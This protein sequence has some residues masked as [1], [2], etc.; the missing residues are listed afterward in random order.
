[1]YREKE[2]DFM[3]LN[4]HKFSVILI[5]VLSLVLLSTVA[6][7][8]ASL[9]LKQIGGTGSVQKSPDKDDYATNE[10]V[11]IEATPGTGYKFVE[12]QDNDGNTLT[13]NQVYTF[14]MPDTDTTYTAVYERYDY[15]VTVMQGEGSYEIED[16]YP[17]ITFTANP[18]GGF[19]FSH[20]SGDA[21]PAKQNQKSMTITIEEDTE[22]D[23]NFSQGTVSDLQVTPSYVVFNT[24]FREFDFRTAAIA[25]DEE[26]QYVEIG[27]EF[28]TD[29]PSVYV[30]DE[31]G[32]PILGTGQDGVAAGNTSGGIYYERQNRK[33]NLDISALNALEDGTTGEVRL[34]SLNGPRL[35][36]FTIRGSFPKPYMEVELNNHP[37]YG[38]LEPNQ[39]YFLNNKDNLTV[40]ITANSDLLSQNVVHPFKINEPVVLGRDLGLTSY[41]WYEVTAADDIGNLLN[42]GLDEKY[43]LGE[44]DD[45][46]NWV[47]DPAAIN[48]AL[49]QAPAGTSFRIAAVRMKAYARGAA[50]YADQKYYF[51]IDQNKPQIASVTPGIDTDE[52]EGQNLDKQ[53]SLVDSNAAE[54]AE[55][56]I[57]V[58]FNEL[59][60]GIAEEEINARAIKVDDSRPLDEIV[61]DYTDDFDQAFDQDV[62]KR[63]QIINFDEQANEA[64]IFPYGK[65]E[66]GK[67]VVRITVKDNAGNVND[68]FDKEDGGVIGFN[69]VLKVNQGSPII[70]NITL[71][72]NDG[73]ETAGIISTSGGRLQFDV[74]NSE[75]LR[76]QVRRRDKRGETWTYVSET[77]LDKKTQFINRT[78]SDIGVPLEDGTYEVIMVADDIKLQ[79]EVVTAI[80]AIDINEGSDIETEVEDA[81]KSEL[82]AEN[83][84][85]NDNRTEVRAF[86]FRVD[87]TPPQIGG[88]KYVNPN[89]GAVEDPND[90]G[91]FGI[92]YTAA[93]T[94]QIKISDSSSL[95][96]LNIKIDDISAGEINRDTEVVDG[97]K[98]N[99]ITF[100]PNIALDDGSH[101]IKI[102][103]A[104]KW[105]NPTD[106]GDT[107]YE[108]VFENIFETQD[109]AEGISFNISDNP[110]LSVKEASTIEVS[111]PADQTLDKSTLEV[112]IG[113]KDSG[114]L[115]VDG[116]SKAAGVQGFE[117]ISFNDWDRFIIFAINPWTAGQN[118]ISVTVEDKRGNTTGNSVQ[119]RVYNYREGFGFGR[120]GKFLL[121]KAKKLDE[122]AN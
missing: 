115:I 54:S 4:W 2:E 5:L 78:F 93:P 68:Q 21:P 92:L 64:T 73:Q 122:A 62:T 86:R 95:G 72:D 107:P 98:V 119:F 82:N 35:L 91:R 74:H 22:L 1:M 81:I 55:P 15:S 13:T 37:Q 104:D 8:A 30:I 20:W 117:I 65:L 66:E 26:K 50:D 83:L 77:E 56:E 11:T 46:D 101:S 79:E 12:W 57:R 61:Q 76:Y 48:N 32:N 44:Y 18:G 118:K 23:L 112:R 28:S 14:N 75:E 113:D 85:L 89:S 19:E 29:A 40:N 103:V 36:E 6:S 17:Q 60:S 42:G 33:I 111:L 99:T 51:A 80:E 69:F 9:D 41:T 108:K 59:L 52:L 34:G 90:D 45:K 24:G 106:E 110:E 97:K 25:P 47:M 53:I 7:Y 105:G 116:K 96:D 70:N 43:K 100:A 38:T 121:E 102:D 94:F 88:I 27:F 63:F 71:R 109:V 16:N 58:E 84:R 120:L 114:R 87:G 67:Y 10:E 49:N 3:K 39:L 31:N